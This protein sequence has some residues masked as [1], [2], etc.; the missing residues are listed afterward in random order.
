M[1]KNWQGSSSTKLK[2]LRNFLKESLH[3]QIKQASAACYVTVSSENYNSRRTVE[4]I[5]ATSTG[6]AENSKVLCMPLFVA[7]GHVGSLK[8]LVITLP[9]FYLGEQNIL[10][11]GL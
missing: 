3:S 1:K 2:H 5:A 11:A 10:T 7:H 9:N 6:N 8:C 4:N